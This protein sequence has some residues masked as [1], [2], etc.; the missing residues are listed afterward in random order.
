MCHILCHNLKKILFRDLRPSFFQVCFLKILSTNRI[1]IR[2]YNTTRFLRITR[3]KPCSQNRPVNEK[4]W[5]IQPTPQSD[6]PFS[7]YHQTF[8]PR[9][10]Q[11]S[12]RYF[13]SDF[14]DYRTFSMK[15]WFYFKRNLR[16]YKICLL[17]SS[18]LFRLTNGRKSRRFR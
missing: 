10:E 5:A 13:R 16:Y 17:A 4:S 18:P 15:Y 3:N 6:Q 9:G 7:I 2:S 12:C 1:E 14:L 8:V 11:I